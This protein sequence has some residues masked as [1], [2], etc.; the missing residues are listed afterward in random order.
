MPALFCYMFTLFTSIMNAVVWQP[1]LWIALCVRILVLIQV[2]IMDEGC[3]E[4]VTMYSYILI[5]FASWV[6]LYEYV[7]LFFLIAFFDE[8]IAAVFTLFRKEINS[9]SQSI[10]CHD[11]RQLPAILPSSSSCQLQ[12]FTGF[13]VRP[14]AT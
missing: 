3:R 8:I 5:V 9:S 10:T 6:A 1:L 11:R 2:L 7:L 4:S 14:P 12:C 13:S